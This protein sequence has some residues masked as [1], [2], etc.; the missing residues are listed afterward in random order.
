VVELRILGG[1]T[2]AEAAVVLGVSHT[3]IEGDWFTAKAWLRKE[4]GSTP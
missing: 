3:T 4:L 2:I 1:L